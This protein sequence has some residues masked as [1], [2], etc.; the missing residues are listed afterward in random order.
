MTVALERV[1]QDLQNKVAGCKIDSFESL[2]VLVR[3]S[4]K[5]ATWY[6]W[7]CPCRERER[8]VGFSFDPDSL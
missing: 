2:V 3:F 1:L 4:Y 6:R 5:S 8:Q 7:S